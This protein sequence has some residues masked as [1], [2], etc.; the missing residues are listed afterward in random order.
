METLD[1]RGTSEQEKLCRIFP[2]E[3]PAGFTGS[4][5]AECLRWTDNAVRPVISTIGCSYLEQA[6][7]LARLGK[8]L[9]Q[10]VNLLP[11]A[12][13]EAPPMADNIEERAKQD[14]NEEKARGLA[15]KIIEKASQ[16]FA[17]RMI[18]QCHCFDISG[19]Y[20][21]GGQ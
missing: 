19:K 3:W 18:Q 13:A 9:Y 8:M 10:M 6:Q 12:G 17:E 5:R 7:S 21:M 4:N 14:T 11:G 16:V 15:D 20:E 1:W 2:V